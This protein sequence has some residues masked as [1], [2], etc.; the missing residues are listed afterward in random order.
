MSE[1]RRLHSC[2]L[3]HSYYYVESAN[4]NATW[5]S[6]TPGFWTSQTGSKNNGSRVH[7]FSL[8]HKK[9]RGYLKFFHSS[10]SS[11][12]VLFCSENQPSPS[13]NE[14]KHVAFVIC[15]NWTKHSRPS[16]S[17]EEHFFCGENSGCSWKD[18]LTEH[19]PFPTDIK[20]HRPLSSAGYLEQFY[21]S[22]CPARLHWRSLWRT[23]TTCCVFAWGV[24][25]TVAY[26]I[27]CC[28]WLTSYLKVG[29]V[30]FVECS[31]ALFKES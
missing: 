27:S 8:V 5:T 25:K 23:E 6:V 22:R 12:S 20:V 17:T 26:L 18:R 31:S 4:W 2:S 19:F 7:F 9:K 1:T 28:V 3:L 10:R 24:S 11:V 13:G 21:L 14:A 30:W 15:D 29:T 16:P